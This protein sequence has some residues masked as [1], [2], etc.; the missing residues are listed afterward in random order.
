M[1]FLDT[2]SQVENIDDTVMIMRKNFLV[3]TA[4]YVTTKGQK[5]AQ[6][7]ILNDPVQLE[8]IGLALHKFGGEGQLWIEILKDDGSGKP[9]EHLTS[10]DILPLPD[11]KYFPGYEWIDFPFDGD[12][13]QLSPGRYWIALGYTGSPVI[14]WFFT[15]GKPVGP[16]DGTRYKTMFDEDWSRS[17]TYEFNYRIIGKIGK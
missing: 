2:R 1:D 17:L 12:P 10:S 16:S 5:Y 14:N 13:V 4:E 15:Y 7:F 6:T 9:G 11:I 3:E 8:K